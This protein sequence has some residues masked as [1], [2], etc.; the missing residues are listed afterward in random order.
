M[1][2]TG[3]VFLLMCIVTAG[4]LLLHQVPTFSINDMESRPVNMLSDIFPEEDDEAE[5]VPEPV[6]PA[7]KRQV[8]KYHPQGVEL[9][10]DFSGGK[11]GGMDLFYDKLLHAKTQKPTVRIAYF[12]DSFIEGD[13]L[14]CDL[15]EILQTT[16]GGSGPGWVDC[17][18]GIGSNRPTVTTRFQNIKENVVLKKP[19]NAQL[20]AISQRYYHASSGATLRLTGTNYRPH[21]G[22]W[23]KA[24]LF[25]MTDADFTVKAKPGQ[26]EYITE[27]FTPSSDVQIQ[28]TKG[29]MKEIAYQFPNATT[30][31]RLF[32][33]ALDGNNGVALDNFSM[34]G[35][36][37]FSLANI[38]VSTLKGIHQY[39]PYDLIIL[40]FGLNVV[41][42]KATDKQCRFYIDRMKKVIENMHEAFPEAGILVFSVPDR[43]QRGAGGFHT[44][45]GIKR[46][47]GFQRILASECGVAFLNVHQIMGG[48]ESML[49]FVEQGLAAKDY[50]HMNFK[51]GK[52]IAEG[53]FK[54][55]QAGVENYRRELEAKEQ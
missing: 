23:S 33:V 51:G 5:A 1:R 4:L 17:G 48:N 36:P 41:D 12:G 42:D 3:R 7:P 38:P 13:I 44:L 26:N 21:V 39:R 32:G 50:T 27:E 25:F 2:T 15:R 47:I 8:V 37:G 55:I 30:K 11:T 28:T 20:Q 35:T 6:V 16:Y 45:G 40:Q 54:S 14:T 24:T 19:F 31:T 22:N 9:I 29:E 49:K 43:V 52:V 10:E 53:I 46:L 34:R 18:G